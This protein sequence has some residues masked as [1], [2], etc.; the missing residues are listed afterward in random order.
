MDPSTPKMFPKPPRLFDQAQA[1]YASI[2]DE[3]LTFLSV[4]H[5]KPSI[6]SLKKLLLNFF[7]FFSKN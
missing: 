5:V 1:C 3:L 4:V 6:L 2:E 7:K